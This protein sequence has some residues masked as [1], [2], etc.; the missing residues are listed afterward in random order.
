LPAA[1]LNHLYKQAREK[2]TAVR[3]ALR[4]HQRARVN[5]NGVLHRPFH[6]DA[7]MGASEA[8]SG[9]SRMTAWRRG[10]REVYTKSLMSGT[11]ASKLETHHQ[12]MVQRTGI[13]FVDLVSKPSI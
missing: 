12:N 11:W 8:M 5:I 13:G 10:D 4:G 1:D 9:Q 7:P 3:S 6:D 2:I